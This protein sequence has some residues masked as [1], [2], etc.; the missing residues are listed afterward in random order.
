MATDSYRR[1]REDLDLASDLGLSAYRFSIEWSRVEP[2]PQVFDQQAIDHYRRIA[3]EVRARGM[4]PIITLWHFAYP[5]WLD[6]PD[7]S[8]LR[9]WE[10]FDAPEIF[11]RYVEKVI[12]A[13]AEVQ[14]LWLTINEPV[15]FALQG[16]V[17]GKWPPGR[18]EPRAALAVLRNLLAAHGRAYRIIHARWPKA[19][20]AFNNF[21]LTLHLT[22]VSEAFAKSQAR[23][24]PVWENWAIQPDLWL[25]VALRPTLRAEMDFAALDYYFP[26]TL[27]SADQ[28]PWLW[29]VYPPGLYEAIKHY[30]N[31]FRKPV[32]IAENG[33]ATKDGAPRA[34]G[35]TREAHLV[36]HVREV[37]RA[38]SDGI[39]VFGYCYWSLLDNYE[40]GSF[41]PRFGLYQVDYGSETLRRIPTAAVAYYRDIVT[42]NNLRSSLLQL[43]SDARGSP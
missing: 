22:A 24:R 17:F 11:G 4:T 3:R 25:L 23:R 35:W 27:S 42:H 20:V 33:L 37:L 34:D 39:P 30:A 41:M 32:L 14:P 43:V 36:A 19:L 40:W 16:Y 15:I 26:A 10:R 8:G 38:R 21:A 6:E 9:G 28:S 7:A 13:F 12:G 18:R 29:P 2:R 5:A 1:Y 31:F